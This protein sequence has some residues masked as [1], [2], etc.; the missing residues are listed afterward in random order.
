M[1]LLDWTK[2]QKLLPCKSPHEEVKTNYRLAENIGKPNEVTRLS[3]EC[4]RSM[5]I[6]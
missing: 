5:L 3:R 1:G 4:S 2:I 6:I